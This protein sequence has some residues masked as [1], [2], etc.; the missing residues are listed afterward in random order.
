MLFCSTLEKTS[1]SFSMWL[2]TLFVCVEK[3]SNSCSQKGFIEFLKSFLLRIFLVK[4]AISAV[5]YE[6]GHIYWRNPQWNPHILSSVTQMLSCQYCEISKNSIFYR[7]S[8]VII[9]FRNFM[10]GYNS[11]DVCEHNI[12]IFHFFCAITL[13]FFITIVLQS[14]VHGYLAL[15]LAPNFLVNVTFARITTSVPVL[16]WLNQLVIP[17]PP[18]NLLQKIRTWV[19][20]LLCCYY[21]SLETS[22]NA[23]IKVTLPENKLMQKFRQHWGMLQREYSQKRTQNRKFKLYRY[24]LQGQI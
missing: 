10:W 24:N 5:S 13:F 18:G 14:G 22:F 1:Y 7:I 20:W 2:V 11:L 16:F 21:F 17:T 9:L 12:D 4:V 23:W 6:F 19:Y 3:R 15:A 8:P